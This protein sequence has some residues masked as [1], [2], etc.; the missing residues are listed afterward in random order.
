MRPTAGYTLVEMLVVILVMGL[1]AALISAV[2]KPD[3]RSLLHTETERLAQLLNLAA[4]ESRLTGKPVRWTSD[5]TAYRFWRLQEDSSWSEVQ[6]SSELLRPRTLPD[7]ML[8]S[9]F[10]LESHQQQ[11]AIRL[12]FVPYGL[13]LAY[14][15]GM[16]LG[17]DHSSVSASPVGDAQ[18]QTG[19]ENANA[20]H[21][22]K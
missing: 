20:I 2:A 7:G 11:N 14:T 10:R 8:I 5:G 6:D 18:A 15:I 1:L 13:S 19:P 9:D 3:E 21:V 4:T 12:D 17:N 16:S 22:Q